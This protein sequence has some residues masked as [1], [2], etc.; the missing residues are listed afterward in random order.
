MNLEED[1]SVIKLGEEVEFAKN[2]EPTKR[3]VLRLFVKLFDPL[4]LVFSLY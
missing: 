3:N 4:V 2:L 1:T